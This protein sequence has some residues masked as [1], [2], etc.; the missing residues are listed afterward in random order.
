MTGPTLKKM[1]E[2][3]ESRLSEYVIEVL[4]ILLGVDVCG[5]VITQVLL[6]CRTRIY[7]VL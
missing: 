7:A 4:N 2:F 5:M 6:G 1:H 3:D